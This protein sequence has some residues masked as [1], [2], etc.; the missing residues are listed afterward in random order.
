M[1]LMLKP[2]EVAEELRIGRT[3]VFELIKSGALVSVK[4]G[5]SR[6]VRAADLAAYVDSLPAE[7]P[8][9]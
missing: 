6:L 4:I 9:P 2:E 7:S 1:T 5:N 3:R 8:S